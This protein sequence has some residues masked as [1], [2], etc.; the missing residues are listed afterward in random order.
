MNFDFFIPCLLSEASLSTNRWSENPGAGHYILTNVQRGSVIN[1][2]ESSA[3]KTLETAGPY[4][5]FSVN[6]SAYEYVAGIHHTNGIEGFWGH[7]K[8][9]TKGTNVGVSKKHMWKYVAEYQYRY[10]FRD[11]GTFGLFN[12]L[13]WAFQGPRLVEP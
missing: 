1:T 3:Y 4:T 5:H 7:F 10:N 12:R 11:L 9:G 6:H 13:V 2:D 8:K